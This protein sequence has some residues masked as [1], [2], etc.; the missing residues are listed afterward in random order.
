MTRTLHLV[1]LENLL[2]DPRASGDAALATLHDY[3]TAAGW[4]AGDLVYVA[5]NPHLAARIGFDLD[6]S[7]RLHCAPG[8][9]GVDV[10]VVARPAAVHRDWHRGRFP[11]VA[12]EPAQLAA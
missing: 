4:R 5:T 8:R 7:C 11:V 2:G 12:L 3:C 9:D 6:V 10:A 1:D